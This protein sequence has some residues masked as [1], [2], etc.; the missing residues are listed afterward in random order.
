MCLKEL[1]LAAPMHSGA[2][3]PL[4]L[5]LSLRERER[6][7]T[8]RDRSPNGKHLP[9]L[10]MVLPLPEGEGWGEGEGRFLQISYGLTSFRGRRLDQTQH[11]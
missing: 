9:A 1:T 7:S 6:F 4:T 5:A 8:G 3:F 11:P 2:L 10:R